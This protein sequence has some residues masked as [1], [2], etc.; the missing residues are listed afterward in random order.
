MLLDV[1][2]QFDQ[3]R[4]SMKTERTSVRTQ[5]EFKSQEF[6][7][8]YSNV[9][10]EE[11]TPIKQ[12]AQFSNEYSN[13][14]QRSIEIQFTVKVKELKST[15]SGITHTGTM[16]TRMASLEQEI[17]QSGIPLKIQDTFKN[18]IT[19]HIQLLDE[20]SEQ[21]QTIN[22]ATP[23]QFAVSKRSRPLH[24]STT[25]EEELQFLDTFTQKL[26][27]PKTV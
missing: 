27:L 2:S 26:D 3:F 16:Q 24:D 8:C 15:Q 13:T 14:S 22:C 18:I 9:D 10:P 12:P 21:L 5:H 11:F 17:S 6:S 19:P 20:R 23:N 4:R 25:S 7:H 1:Q